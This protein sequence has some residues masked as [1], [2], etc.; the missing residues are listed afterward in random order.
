MRAKTYSPSYKTALKCVSYLSEDERT[1]EDKVFTSGT[2]DSRKI[3]KWLESI[4]RGE[5]S[6]E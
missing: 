2:G 5:V 1:T 4:D 3:N 6:L